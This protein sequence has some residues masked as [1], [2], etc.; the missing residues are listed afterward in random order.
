[1]DPGD[2][3]Q[4]K[5]ALLVSGDPGRP[6]LGLIIPIVLT[7]R[8]QAVFDGFTDHGAV[9]EMI[10]RHLY[11]F[12]PT[13]KKVILSGYRFSPFFRPLIPSWWDDFPPP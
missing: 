6:L 11:G 5:R 2:V 13:L 3:A 10:V 1:M 8:N 12:Y 4:G 7:S 9:A